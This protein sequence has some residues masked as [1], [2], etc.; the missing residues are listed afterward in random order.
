MFRMPDHFKHNE[1]IPRD[2]K[3][4]YKKYNIKNN[5]FVAI[6]GT[7]YNDK[8]RHIRVEIGDKNTLYRIV[9][10]NDDFNKI[11]FVIENESTK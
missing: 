8:D 6:H 11:E 2:Y 1:T 7:I 4:E 10:I 9:G 3:S 5:S